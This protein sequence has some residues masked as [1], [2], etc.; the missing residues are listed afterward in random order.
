M[1]RDGAVRREREALLCTRGERRTCE[2]E[3][4]NGRQKSITEFFHDVSP[5]KVVTLIGA[6]AYS[7]PDSLK[8]V[9]SGCSNFLREHRIART[10]DVNDQKNDD[11]QE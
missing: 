5:F 8:P 11:H 3:R 10:E 7:R 2:H 6:D 9:I 4:G 1:T